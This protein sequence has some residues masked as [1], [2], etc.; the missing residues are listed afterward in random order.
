MKEGIAILT[1]CVVHLILGG[2]FLLI[3]VRGGPPQVIGFAAT[4]AFLYLQ[5]MIGD[6]ILLPEHGFNMCIVALGTISIF[7]GIIFWGWL[8]FS[9]NGNAAVNAACVFFQE[10]KCKLRWSIEFAGFIGLILW[11]IS[12]ISQVFL[13]FYFIYNRPP[14]RSTKLRK[15]RSNNVLDFSSMSY[16][17]HGTPSLTCVSNSSTDNDK[18]TYPAVTAMSPVY[19]GEAS[20]K[21]WMLKFYEGSLKDQSKTKKNL[22]F[23]K[24]LKIKKNNSLS[25]SRKLRSIRHWKNFGHHHFPLYTTWHAPFSQTRYP[26][27]S[28]KTPSFLNMKIPLINLHFSKNRETIVEGPDWNTWDFSNFDTSMY[29]NSFSQEAINLNDN[30][31]NNESSSALNTLHASFDTQMTQSSCFRRFFEN[32]INNIDLNNSSR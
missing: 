17:S 8:F 29:S 5:L 10:K 14:K 21:E 11:T 26:Y 32:N 18:T 13:Y 23:H 19:E 15:S 24:D 16:A 25:S 12:A 7:I 30:I 6:A 27:F 9:G 4:A 3:A 2:Y 22:Q 1:C 31:Y 20:S 28:K